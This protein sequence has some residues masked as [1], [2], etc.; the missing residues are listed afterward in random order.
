MLF[1]CEQYYYGLVFAKKLQKWGVF[2]RF[3]LDI[4]FVVVN[5]WKFYEIP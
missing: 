4:R 2:K 3:M 5:L 1:F